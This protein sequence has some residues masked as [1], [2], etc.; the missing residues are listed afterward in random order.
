MGQRTARDEGADSL[1]GQDLPWDALLCAARDGVWVH[2][3]GRV[4]Y[5]NAALCELLQRRPSELLGH[6]IYEFMPEYVREAVRRRVDEV[7]RDANASRVAEFTMLL[8][9]GNPV[10]V[11]AWGHA[12]NLDGEVNI[13]AWL[14][15]I[16]QRKQ[17]ERALE[18]SKLRLRSIFDA[19]AEGVVL[20]DAQGGIVESNRAATQ[21]L[22]LDEAE[23]AGRRSIDP[24]WHTVHE[25]GS[26][27]PGT[28]H[29][30]MVT[31]RSGH[32]IRDAVMGV[33]KPNGALTWISINC[34]PLFD[35]HGSVSGVVSSFA[36]ITQRRLV[37]QQLEAQRRLNQRI[38]DTAPIGLALFD[39]SGQCLS[40]NPGML[41]HV[42]ATRAQALASNYYDLPRWKEVGLRDLADRAMH[43]N[44]PLTMQ[45]ELMT[46]FGRQAWLE[47]TCR[48]VD[49]GDQAGLMLMTRDLSDARRAEQALAASELRYRTLVQ[50]AT[51]GIFTANT[52][53]RYTDVNDA[54]CRMLGYSR[55]EIL[56]MRM[57]DLVVLGPADPPLQYERLR[58]GEPVLSERR[59]RRKDGSVLTAEISGRLLPSGQ[60][61]GIVR[62]IGPR[63]A[64]EE[65]LLAKEVAEQSSA[66]KSEF[67]SRVSHELRTPLNAILGFTDLLLSGAQGRLDE[68]QQGH[69]ALVRR[70]GQ[71]L[72]TLINDLLDLSRIESGMLRLQLCGIDI[73][74]ALQEVLE[75]LR[76]EAG[77]GPV[78][79]DLE[80][81]AGLPAVQGDATRLQQVLVN[82]VHNAIKYNRPGGHVRVRAAIAG[83][84]ICVSVRDDGPGLT[85]SQIDN[86]YQPF[87][88][89]GAEVRRVP[90]TGIGLV[91]TRQLVNLMGGQLRVRSEPGS[92]TEFT[93]Q[94]PLAPV[95]FPPG[96]EQS[97]PVAVPMRRDD[98]HGCVLYVDDDEVNQLLMQACFALRPNV[99][100]L[101]AS[102]GAAGLKL[103]AERCP[104]LLLLDMSLPD[105][106][107]LD[108][109]RRLRQLPALARV[110]CIAVSANAMPEEI[111][112]A[113]AQ[114]VDEYLTK[115]LEVHVLLGKVDQVLQREQ[116]SSAV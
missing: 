40:V 80:L 93:L 110:P 22:G 32:P 109:L 10:E 28:N 29:P 35:V 25:D 3:R 66:A 48:R 62:D 54:G 18:S 114:G 38:I 112:R 51:D 78:Q 65:V 46:S 61:L 85:K 15:P 21:I 90:G 73:G 56:S 103:T 100:L 111:A 13:L 97:A 52:D 105:M 96:E 67:I 92:G 41:Q 43:T 8:P 42:G 63:K 53:G 14:R 9:D 24:R 50:Q 76:P 77:L 6:E 23:M 37:D 72:L 101:M 94:L 20:Q 98:V 107:G 30:A 44:E 79:L 81:P 70:S 88:R 2:R 89:L 49:L 74:E 5:V 34:E 58:R 12:V 47:L 113:R 91:I 11:E 7:V 102:D 57:D 17:M 36:D 104:D 16:A 45:A 64:A 69:L 60:F 27:Y 55:E 26:P 33:R 87:N 1:G 68:Q 115:P 82:L 99:E 106:A 95:A 19:L 71:H 83:E 84:S 75:Q 31:L 86:L 59:L 39:Q 108:L 116:R 4:V